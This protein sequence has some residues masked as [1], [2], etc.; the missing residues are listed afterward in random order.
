MTARPLLLGITDASVMHTQLEEFDVDT[1]FRMVKESG[2]FDYYDKTPPPGYETVYRR[3]S[4]KYCLPLLAGGWFYTLGRDEP[5]LEWH[6]RLARDCGTRVHNVQILTNDYSGRLVSDEEI[7]KTYLWAME[8]GSKVSVIP[9]FEVHVNM[10]SEHFGRIARV[11]EMVE[12]R[13]VP[14]NMTLDASHVIFKIANSPEQE[15]QGMRADVLA[16]R[17]ELDP[18]REGSVCQQWIEA[19]YVRHAHARSAAPNGPLNVWATHNGRPGRGIQYPFIRPREGEWHSEWRETDLEP[20]KEIMRRLLRHH[21][22]NPASRLETIST[23]FIPWADYGAG[24][25]YSLFEHSVACAS[26]I[27]SAWHEATRQ[28]TSR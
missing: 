4:E 28:I 11:A 14:F 22:L 1:R 26:W 10:W 24:A 27:R 15:V 18:F 21:A 20:W 2:V 7:A 9:C 17:I 16:G 25:K 6:L 5:L 19:N 8:L 3:A 12:R 13:G 23:E